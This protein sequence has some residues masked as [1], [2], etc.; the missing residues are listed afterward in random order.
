MIKAKLMVL[1]EEI[2]EEKLELLEIMN[3]LEIK[4]AEIRLRMEL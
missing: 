3:N 1:P 4:E 2:Y